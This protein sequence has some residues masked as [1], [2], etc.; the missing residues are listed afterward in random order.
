[1]D[2]R[3]KPGIGSDR[4]DAAKH[5]GGVLRGKLESQADSGENG[6]CA[7]GRGDL[8]KRAPR[9]RVKRANR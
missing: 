7:L 2:D 9:A 4:G 6:G 8:C 1:M 5:V 3:W